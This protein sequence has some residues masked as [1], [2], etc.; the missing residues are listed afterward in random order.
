MCASDNV[1]PGSGAIDLSSYTV[2]LGTFNPVSG[3]DILGG[4]NLL[5]NTSSSFSGLAHYAYGG[6]FGPF[7][8]AY[9]AWS[10]SFGSINDNGQYSV[11]PVSGPTPVAISVRYFD[12][13][14]FYT[15]NKNITVF[16]TFPV[17]FMSFNVVSNKSLVFALSGNP[18]RT[19]VLETST[20][21]VSSG[22]WTPLATNKSDANGLFSFTNSTFTN[23]SRRFF[24]AR[25]LP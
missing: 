16:Q 20:N 24:R 6:N 2:G 3:V 9:G 12:Y 10:C 1:G 18:N 14:Y 25:Q 21:L 19:N 8:T 11:G 4:S 15:A 23:F 13:P 5:Q 22:S 17:Q 7:T